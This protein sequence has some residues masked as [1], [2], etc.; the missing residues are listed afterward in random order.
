MRVF[1]VEDNPVMRAH[2]QEELASI[3]GVKVVHAAACAEEAQQWLAAHPQGWDLALVDIFLA[4][5]HGFQ[6]LRQCRD[7]S[8]Y[9]R[10]VVLSNYTRDPVREHARLAGADAVFDKSFEMEAMLEYCRGLV[11]EPA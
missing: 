2:V 6:V 8:P 9:Q 4:S 7:R 3:C 5:G 11:G 1:L 10:A